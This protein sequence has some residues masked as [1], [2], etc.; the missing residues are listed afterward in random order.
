MIKYLLPVGCFL[1]SDINAQ[2]SIFLFIRAET[3]TQ[4]LGLYSNPGEY[5][6]PNNIGMLV[7]LGLTRVK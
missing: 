2:K 3:Y 6:Q 5:I 4:L 7:E 1:W